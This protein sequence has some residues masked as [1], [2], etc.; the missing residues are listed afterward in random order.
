[1]ENAFFVSCS[2]LLLSKR[3]KDFIMSIKRCITTHTQYTH[4]H[5]VW[6]FFSFRLLFLMLLV[7]K[8]RI[9]KTI[10]AKSEAYT[11]S[12][13]ELPPG[14]YIFLRSF[15]SEFDSNALEYHVYCVCWTEID[16]FP[17]ST[18]KRKEK[19]KHERLNY[20]KERTKN[21]ARM[22][23]K[24]HTATTKYNSEHVRFLK[25][26]AHTHT[27]IRPAEK[28]PWALYIINIL[29]A[30]LEVNIFY[31]KEMIVQWVIDK[32]SYLRVVFLWA[33]SCFFSFSFRL[34]SLYYFSR[35][36]FN[37]NHI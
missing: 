32:I 19:K 4:L 24:R 33:L 1:M 14:T 7:L 15:F 17:W 29:C 10:I 21:Q 31:G 30:F 3:Q 22:N 23:R 13:S 12:H 9:E 34:S 26:H 20:K 18:K 5:L 2:M 8:E 35:D 27:H 37:E 25:E 16:W 36:R 6:F 11:H 28:I